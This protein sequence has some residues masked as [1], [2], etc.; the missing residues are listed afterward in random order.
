MF[1]PPSRPNNHSLLLL[2]GIIGVVLLFLVLSL[3][4]SA[5]PGPAYSNQPRPDLFP[6]GVPSHP[7]LDYY[8]PLHKQLE[9]S[10]TVL[11]DYKISTGCTDQSDYGEPSIGDSIKAAMDNEYAEFGNVY[12][13]ARSAG[14]RPDITLSVLCGA[15]GTSTLG[16]GVI[17]CLCG[18]NALNGQT[19]FVS[20]PYSDDIQFLGDMRNYY[21]VSQ[22]SIVL[23]ELFHA[24]ATFNEEY[25]AGYDAN[26][27]CTGLYAAVP[28]WPDIMNTGPDSRHLIG[29]IERNRWGRVHG[30]GAPATYGRGDGF[31]WFCGNGTGRGLNVAL[32]SW[33][34]VNDNLDGTHYKYIGSIALA[35][36]PTDRNGCRGMQTTGYVVPGEQACIDFWNAVDWK[37]LEYRSDR[38]A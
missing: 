28:N 30:S 37:R 31:V 33:D 36:L 13:W 7:N 20:Y 23:H 14:V 6:S 24:I 12:I 26:L 1:F 15:N 4:A 25:C 9:T 16:S 34:G 8:N 5:D 10:G 21:D 11:W 22:I 38:C 2:M 32:Y 17:G 27:G 19:G 35:S 3:P 18:G 29:D